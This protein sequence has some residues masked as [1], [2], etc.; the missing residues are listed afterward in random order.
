MAIARGHRKTTTRSAKSGS[1]VVRSAEGGKG[2][3][4]VVRDQD[5]SKAL[6][7]LREAKARRSR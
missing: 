2:Q 6:N 5:V 1:F 7:Q 4:R 3:T